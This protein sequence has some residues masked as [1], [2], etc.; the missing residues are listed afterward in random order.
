MHSALGEM[1]SHDCR[2]LDGDLVEM[3]VYP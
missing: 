2:N 3:A 1:V